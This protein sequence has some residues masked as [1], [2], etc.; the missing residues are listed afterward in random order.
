MLY[1]IYSEASQ[2]TKQCSFFDRVSIN[3]KCGQNWA[4]SLL[5]GVMGYRLIFFREN[6]EIALYKN[7]FIFFYLAFSFFPLRCQGYR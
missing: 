4:L 1:Q 5:D 7:R 6:E 3:T 2:T